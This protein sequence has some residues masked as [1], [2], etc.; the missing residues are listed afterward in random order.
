M[1]EYAIMLIETTVCV[2]EY[3]PKKGNEADIVDAFG[4]MTCLMLGGSGAISLAGAG[5]VAY[6]HAASHGF[7]LVLAVM[8][9]AKHFSEKY[10]SE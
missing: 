1:V 6:G 5:T 8:S 9:A 4:M 7:M 3:A 10:G 2:S